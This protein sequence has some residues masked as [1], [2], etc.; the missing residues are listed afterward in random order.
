MA[1]QCFTELSTKAVLCKK[2]SDICYIREGIWH[3]FCKRLEMTVSTDDL[4]C[5]SRTAK[6]SRWSSSTCQEYRSWNVVYHSNPRLSLIYPD[7]SKSHA[8]SATAKTPGESSRLSEKGDSGGLIDEGCIYRKIYI[9][10]YI[11]PIVISP[12]NYSEQVR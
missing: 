10:I 5:P 3:A 4:L 9:I 11:Y 12:V 7:Y 1:Q 8:A 2:Y 6:G